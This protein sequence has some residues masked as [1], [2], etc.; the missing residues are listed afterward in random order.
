MGKASEGLRVY[1]VA[2]ADAEVQVCKRNNKLTARPADEA[3]LQTRVGDAWAHVVAAMKNLGA[4]PESF[5]LWMSEAVRRLQEDFAIR[6][7]DGP[8]AACDKLFSLSVAWFTAL[9]AKS[10]AAAGLRSL[11]AGEVASLK[12]E[13]LM[14]L[15]VVPTDSM[16]SPSKGGGVSEIEKEVAELVEDD[17]SSYPSVSRTDDVFSPAESSEGN[18]LVID[19]T[20]A[21]PPVPV[22][23]FPAALAILG[24]LSPKA[25]SVRGIRSTL[26][27]HQPP[28]VPTY[29]RKMEY[30]SP[31]KS[32]SGSAKRSGSRNKVCGKR[33]SRGTKNPENSSRWGKAIFSSGK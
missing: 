18:P 10:P 4:G 7:R 29:N 8:P 3:T 26:L 30:T 2:A 9:L 15:D 11:P 6:T 5:P 16:P 13:T 21:V 33:G 31:T 28:A 20:P 19:R 25:K 1:A 23:A 12:D 24:E 27:A 22:V 17:S 14:D 32:G